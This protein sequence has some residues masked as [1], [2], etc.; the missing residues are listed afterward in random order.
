MF[1]LVETFGIVIRS[2]GSVFPNHDIMPFSERRPV[3]LEIENTV[4]SDCLSRSSGC[5]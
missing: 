2:T 5:R 1:W 3:F 4:V